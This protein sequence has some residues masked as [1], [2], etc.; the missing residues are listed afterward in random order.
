M[1]LR[2]AATAR[3]DGLH[4]VVTGAAGALGRTVTTVLAKAGHTVTGIDITK[5]FDEADGPGLALG[6]V[7]LGV[8]G[9]V[10]EA[11]E[12]AAA[13]AG[14]LHALV[15]IAG[16][17]VWESVADGDPA[18]W[19]RMFDINV[20]ATLN[21]SRAAL[22][23]FAQDPASIVNV[24]AAA[25]LKAGT[26]M[27]AYTAAKSGVMRLTEALAEELKPRGIRVNAILPSIIDTPANRKDMPDADYSEWVT[28]GELA[29]VIAFLI[30]EK[31]SGITGALIPVT[32]RV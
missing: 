26:G 13:A 24:G 28:A 2:G 6:G 8:P 7:D 1:P 17:F 23:H 25:A 31:A 20:L 21:A 5:D 22:N 14:P 32:G 16:G 18:S 19:Q 11:L 10:H 9:Q 29:E 15:N 12:K 30:S 27:G 4:V 3:T